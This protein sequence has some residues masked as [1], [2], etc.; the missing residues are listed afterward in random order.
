LLVI[1]TTKSGSATATTFLASA[2]VRQ[3]VCEAAACA[4]HMAKRAKTAVS[5]RD[6]FDII[7]SFFHRQ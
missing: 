5:E 2:D 4:E 3:G 7:L 6:F 1:A